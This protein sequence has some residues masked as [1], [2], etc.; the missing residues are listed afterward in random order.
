MLAKVQKTIAKYQMLAPGD[1]VVVAVS[2]GPD[3]LVL[4]HVLYSLRSHYNIDLLVAHYNH[5][6]RPEAARE[7][8]RVRAFAGELGLPCY[9]GEGP[10]AAYA[11][12]KKLSLQAAARDLRYQFLERIVRETN[13]QKLALAHQL[14]DQAETIVMH[15]LRGPSPRGLSGIPPVRGHIIRPLIEISRQEIEAY[16][17]EHRLEAVFDPSND[18]KIYLRNRVR[19]E[20]MPVLKEYNSNLTLRLSQSAEIFREEDRYLEEET[21]RWWA[22]LVSREGG[23]LL[24]SFAGYRQAPLVIQRRLLRRCFRETAARQEDLSFSQVERLRRWLE[25]PAA[26]KKLQ[27]PWGVRIWFDGERIIFG[28]E[29]PVPGKEPGFPYHYL[30]AGPG[31]VEL[32]QGRLHVAYVDKIS[33]AEEE[34]KELGPWTVVVDAGKV[35]FPLTVRTRRP[36]DRFFPLGLGGSKKLK[37]FFIDLKL[38]AEKRD[39]VPLVVSAG[40]EIIW[41][42]GL[43]LDERFKVSAATEQ[44]LRLSYEENKPEMV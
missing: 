3:S 16:L 19:L 13:S 26:G 6:L 41:V 33:W 1:K 34:L 22:R 11:R 44:V 20:L 32:P 7:A 4:L 24:V 21:D 39:Q 30:L 43:R 28:Q 5:R 12:E 27:W 42:V 35:S 10:V 25:Q 40:G 38:P 9:V 2:G 17:A 15:F 37:D 29:E 31:V 18:K 36:G 23:R 8:E 14:D